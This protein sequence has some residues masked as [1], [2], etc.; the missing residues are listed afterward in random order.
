MILSI[1]TEKTFTGNNNKTC[2]WKTLS[3][4][5]I[6]G[7]FFNMIKNIYK[8]TTTNIVFNGETLEAFLLRS[9]TGQ[10]V[11][12]HYNLTPGSPIANAVRQGMELQGTEIKKEEVKLI[13]DDMTV[14]I[15]IWDNDQ[16]ALG[17][18]E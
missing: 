9:R 2:S 8:E 18:N 1:D 14:Y 5:G 3:K 10:D 11:L 17:T 13:T 16:K 6:E 15:K 7:K 12:S 4:L